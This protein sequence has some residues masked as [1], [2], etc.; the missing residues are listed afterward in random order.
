MGRV[1]KQSESDRGLAVRVHDTY[2]CLSSR[3]H[4]GRSYGYYD[5]IVRPTF[6][7]VPF[8][9]SGRQI[10][11]DRRRGVTTGSD[12]RVVC[13][14]LLG[15]MISSLVQGGPLP[16]R[17]RCIVINI[18]SP[19]NRINSAFPSRRESRLILCGSAVLYPA[20]VRH[21]FSLV[22]SMPEAGDLVGLCGS[23]SN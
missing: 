20:V 19:A 8:L 6:G 9:P 21:N 3:I 12:H 7:C 4:P 5:R 13:L 16:R 18:V 22:A 1:A 2:H 11:R 14:A 17:G 10:T 15:V 23:N